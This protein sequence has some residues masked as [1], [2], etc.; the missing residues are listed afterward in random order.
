MM[1]TRLAVLGRVGIALLPALIVLGTTFLADLRAPA[2]VTVHDVTVRLVAGLPPERP[3]ADYDFARHYAWLAS[4]RTAQAFT[5]VVGGSVF[6]EAVAAR[7]RAVD[8]TLTRQAVAG[9]LRADAPDSFKLT[10]HVTAP[11]AAQAELI[12]RSALSELTQNG[13]NYFSVL[14]DAVTPP[15]SVLEQGSA[16]PRLVAAPRASASLPLRLGLAALAGLALFGALAWLEG[17]RVRATDPAAVG[18]PILA[19]IPAAPSGR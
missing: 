11:S 13:K 15:L 8:A 14:A 2:P 16:Q 7:A 4:E 17:R 5:S 10:L 3:D 9:A 12:A 1:R 6:A 18:L 19:R